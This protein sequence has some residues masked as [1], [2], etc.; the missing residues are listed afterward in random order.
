MAPVPNP[1]KAPIP[2]AKTFL[3][4]L[5]PYRD[6]LLLLGIAST[7]AG[8][9]MIHVPSALIFLGIALVVLSVLMSR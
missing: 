1:P 9:A 7:T 8:V 2:E 6:A 3:E 4:R 5:I